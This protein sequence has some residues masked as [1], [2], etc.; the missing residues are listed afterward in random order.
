VAKTIIGDFF[1]FKKN[2]PKIGKQIA[3]VL[4]T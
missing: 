1:S 2:S 3:K 4:E